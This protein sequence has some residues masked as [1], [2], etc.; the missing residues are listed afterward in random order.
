MT[1][2]FKPIDGDNWKEAV[3]LKVHDDQINFVASN[4]KSLIQAAYEFTP[5]AKPFSMYVDDKM[6]GFLMLYETDDDSGDL[7][8]NRYM[9]GSEYQGKG[10]GRQGLL[11]LIEQTKAEGKWQKLVLSYIPDNERA[12]DV[13]ASVGFIEAGMIEAWGEMKTELDLG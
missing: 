13:Y 11:T 12:R 7:W 8:I 2:T 3:A 4:E 10:Y 5:H 9:V 6:V 1:I